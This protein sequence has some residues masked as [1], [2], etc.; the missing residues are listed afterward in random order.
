MDTRPIPRAGRQVS[1]IGLGTRG[2]ATRRGAAEGERAITAAIDTGC[3]LID[4]AP[5]WADS[6]Q[7]VGVALRELRARDRVVVTSLIEPLVPPPAAQSTGLIISL[8]P[9]GAKLSVVLPPAYVQRAVE[10]SLRAL[11]LDA[12]PLA[13]LN[14]WRDSWIDDR[15][16]PELVGTLERMVYEGKVLAWGVAA[17]DGAPDD[18]VLA[19]AQPWVAAVQVR[20]SLFDR[21]ADEQLV[22]AATAAG[23]AVLAREPLAGGALT[24]EI[25]P[26]ARFLPRDERSSWPPERLAAIVTDLARLAALVTTTSP[27]ATSTP[28]GK[29]IIE[30][31]R[32]GDDLEHRTVAEL[33][34]RDAIDAPAITAAIVGARTVAHVLTAILCADGRRLA[35]TLRAALDRRSW[36]GGWYPTD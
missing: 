12:I 21:S 27:A 26:G 4:V 22:P 8:R 29:A 28:D 32:R 1:A 9:T 3:T 10:D 31:M 5:A 20:R 17:R 23:V 6:Q 19:C 25:G 24:G 15:A 34:L 33:A 11:R 18:A 13:L 14:G 2:L 35:P 36:G 30:A 16:F 7:L